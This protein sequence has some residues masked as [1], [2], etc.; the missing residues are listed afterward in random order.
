MVTAAGIGFATRTIG[1]DGSYESAH[2]LN[3]YR[4]VIEVNLIGTF[5]CVR[6]GASAMSLNEADDD[7]CKGAIVTVTSVAAF[8]G[9]IGQAAYSSS[10]GGVVGMTLPVARDLVGRRHPASTASPPASSTRRSTARARPPRRSRPTSARASCSRS[11]SAR[12]TSSRRWPPSC[13]PT[14]T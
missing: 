4:K 7:G 1:R 3:I 2:D 13:S 14:A 12:P 5:N 6:L 11:A 10:K 9:Q 8:D